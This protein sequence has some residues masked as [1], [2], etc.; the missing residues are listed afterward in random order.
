MQK[1]SKSDRQPTKLKE[2]MMTALSVDNTEKKDEE[3]DWV[4]LKALDCIRY[5]LE[6]AQGRPRHRGDEFST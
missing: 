6:A 1:G 2:E 3:D 5:H 4:E